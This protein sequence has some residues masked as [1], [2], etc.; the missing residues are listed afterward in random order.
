MYFLSSSFF[1]SAMVLVSSFLIHICMED[2]RRGEAE[3]KNGP[4]STKWFLDEEAWWIGLGSGRIGKHL[5]CCTGWSGLM[6]WS[7]SW[8]YGGLLSFFSGIFSFPSLFISVAVQYSQQCSLSPSSSSWS[9]FGKDIP[10][11][12]RFFLVKSFYCK[13]IF[14]QQAYWSWVIFLYRSTMIWFAM[15]SQ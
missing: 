7:V 15:V 11:K 6:K 1:G 4:V 5:A 2:V 13:R 14:L 9:S 3:R 12:N 10:K 8:I